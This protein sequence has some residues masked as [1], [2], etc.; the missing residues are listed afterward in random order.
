MNLQ[1]LFFGS[2]ASWAFPS[3]LGVTAISWVCNI[4]ALILKSFLTVST[5]ASMRWFWICALVDV[6]RYDLMGLHGTTNAPIV[7]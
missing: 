1:A 7:Q 5:I 3:H 4:H 2:L 6:L